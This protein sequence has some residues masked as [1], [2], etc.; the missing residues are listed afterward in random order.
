M[1]LLGMLFIALCLLIMWLE[2]M[3][4]W[5]CCGIAIVAL[6]LLILIITAKY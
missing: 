4:L 1:C 3:K 5:F 6:V 2:A